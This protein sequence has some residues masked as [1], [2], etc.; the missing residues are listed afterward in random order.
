MA[1]LYNVRRHFRLK[2]V[3]HLENTITTLTL[4]KKT[5]DR[6]NDPHHS[7]LHN[8]KQLPPEHL[9]PVTAQVPQSIPC[10]VMTNG[11]AFPAGIKKFLYNLR[12]LPV[13]QP[14]PEQ[15]S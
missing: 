5:Q 8:V 14:S 12:Y 10:S 2:Y 15:E 6:R 11:M 7:T 1:P 9:H 4:S 13:N 3:C